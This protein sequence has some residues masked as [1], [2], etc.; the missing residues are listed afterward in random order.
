MSSKAEA[1]GLESDN[2]SGVTA[3]FCGS[4]DSNPPSKSKLGSFGKALVV[5]GSGCEGND[6]FNRSIGGADLSS[7]TTGALGASCWIV[8]FTGIVGGFD[9]R[10][11]GG[12]DFVVGFVTILYGNKLNK[13]ISDIFTKVNDNNTKKGSY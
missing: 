7:T 6:K 13:I 1:F 10:G 12:F 4:L 8:S 5:G 2:R 11:G 9:G 3:T